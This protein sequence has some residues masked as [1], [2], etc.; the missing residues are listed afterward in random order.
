MYQATSNGDMKS[1]DDT[2]D[3]KLVDD[4][5]ALG[6]LLKDESMPTLVYRN[7]D[8]A[9]AGPFVRVSRTRHAFNEQSVASVATATRRQ[10]R[11]IKESDPKLFRSP[12]TCMAMVEQNGHKLGTLTQAQRT[13]EVSLA[14]VT[15][16]GRAIA[17]LPINKRTPQLW[18][19]ALKSNP[20]AIVNLRLKDLA[21]P[22]MQ[23]VAQ[24]ILRNWRVVETHFGDRATEWAKKVNTVLGLDSTA[25]SEDEESEDEI[26]SAQVRSRA[27]E[28]DRG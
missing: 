26:A 24:G 17:C 15:Q 11:L 12:G 8:G 23:E 4:P 18:L 25:E 28:S 3:L 1:S 6:M 21:R 13:P 2:R 27:R 16:N 22:G 14:A 20:E 7:V 5:R 9:V 19:A 10:L